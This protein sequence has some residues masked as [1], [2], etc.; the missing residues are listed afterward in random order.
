[1]DLWAHE[2]VESEGEQTVTSQDRSCFI[3]RL[4]RRRFPSPEV[5]V[6]HGREVIMHQRIT[7]DAFQRGTREQRSLARDVEQSRTSDN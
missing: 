2:N 1:V 3:E 7:V 5:V 6:I 4:V